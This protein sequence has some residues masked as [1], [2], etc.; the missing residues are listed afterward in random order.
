MIKKKLKYFYMFYKG[1]VQKNKQT[2]KFGKGPK[3]AGV[4]LKPN[5]IDF[6]FKPILLSKKAN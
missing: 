3:G 4:R 5:P 6:C 1:I 2:Q